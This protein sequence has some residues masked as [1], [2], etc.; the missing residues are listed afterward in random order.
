[1]NTPNVPEAGRGERLRT[2]RAALS[3]LFLDTE[4]D[5]RR[6]ARLAR[7]LRGTGLAIE[8]L[9][10]VFHEELEPVLSGNLRTPAGAWAGFDLDW[11]EA[12]I[13]QRRQRHGTLRATID[14]AA[15]ALLPATAARADWARLRA[16]LG[17][18]ESQE[19]NQ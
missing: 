10:H 14:R 15:R 11:L 9:D 13:E 8:V 3:E 2:A 1:V 6:F 17:P 4:L 7:T 5:E 19:T 16:M 18:D 12:E